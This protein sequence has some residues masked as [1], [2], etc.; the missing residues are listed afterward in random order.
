MDRATKKACSA[1]S[2][3]APWGVCIYSGE[4]KPGNRLKQ[5]N[6][7]ALQNVYLTMMDFGAHALA[8]EDFWL[9]C[10]SVK[11]ADIAKCPGGMAQLIGGLLKLMFNPDGHHL[12]LNC[13]TL[14]LPDGSS[15]R[16]VA[17]LACVLGGTN[18]P[19][20]QH[21]CARALGERNAAV[22]A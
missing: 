13:I 19:F 10:A 9:C 4:A 17:T 22:S 5:D 11:S 15:L 16:L 3:S 8:K 6:K 18:L 20:T 1:C 2:A 14:D 21:G 12:G 7:R